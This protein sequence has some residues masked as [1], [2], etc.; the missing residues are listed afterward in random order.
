MGVAPRIERA[1]RAPTATTAALM[2]AF[3]SQAF[4]DVSDGTATWQATAAPVREGE[5]PLGVCPVC[6]DT[7]QEL[8]SG[9]PPTPRL[10]LRAC[11]IPSRE[12]CLGH[13]V[14]KACAKSSVQVGRHEACPVGGA[15]AG[16]TGAFM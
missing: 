16:R 4:E 15:R 10:R 3:V 5:D 1:P 8:Q 2:D 13:F 7:W 9:T 14:C 12:T 11:D 6:R